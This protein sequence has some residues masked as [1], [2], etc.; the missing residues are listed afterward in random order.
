MFRLEVFFN[1]MLEKIN[2]AE[3]LL[4]N[5]AIQDKETLKKKNHTL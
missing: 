3:I 4:T 1:E 2:K 5:K